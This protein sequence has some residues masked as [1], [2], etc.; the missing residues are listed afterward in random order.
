MK[1]LATP[2]GREVFEETGWT[3][4]LSLMEV[5]HRRHVGRFLGG[6][7]DHRE[8]W[9]LTRVPSFRVDSS[10]FTEL[11]NVDGIDHDGDAHLALLSSI[12]W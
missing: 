3:G 6:L 11:E 8:R 7:I 4:V 2:P 12:C 10:G 5:W 1:A 9:Y